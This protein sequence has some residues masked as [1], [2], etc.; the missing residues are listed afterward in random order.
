M[1]SPDIFLMRFDANP[2]NIDF[3]FTITPAI[4]THS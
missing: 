2:L 4:L 1:V 3:F